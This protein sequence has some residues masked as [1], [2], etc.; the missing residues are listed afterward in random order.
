MSF[1]HSSQWQCLQTLSGHTGAINTLAISGDGQT[2]VS[3]SHDHTVCLWNLKT[4]KR[5]FTVF[6]YSQ[7]VYALA[8]HPMLPILATGDFDKKINLWNVTYHELI[9]TLCGEPGT[10]NSHQGFVFALVFSPDQRFLISG[11]ADHTIRLWDAK[12]GKLM[13]TLTS[14]KGPVL[15]LAIS[16]NSQQLVSGSADTTVKIW[17]L[18]SYDPP[19]TLMGH[20]GWVM[21][22]VISPDGNLLVTG[23]G[24][25]MIRIW[26]LATGELLQTLS[27]HLAP[28][29]SLAMSPDGQ[30]L[31]SSSRDGTIK[32]WQLATGELLDTLPGLPP[33]V[34]HSDGKVLVTGGEDYT[35]KVWQFTHSSPVELP[36]LDQVKSWWEVLGVSQRANVDQVKQAYYRLARLH[37]PDLNNSQG[38]GEKMQIINRAYDQFL[39]HQQ[40][41]HSGF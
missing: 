15:A 10:A 30:W 41:R 34:F 4:G 39:R 16:P 23:G 36:T 17:H 38:A 11:S 31:V 12:T 33:V 27:D 21:S 24:D 5:E 18:N 35:L 20:S 25:A 7:E 6:G 2:L 14:H 37:H 13:R 29:L 1:S 8:F 22:V 9:R 28:V 19:R 40:S 32:I 26:S 3:A